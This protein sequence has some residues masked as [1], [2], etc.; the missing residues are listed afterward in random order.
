MH[1]IHVDKLEQ[2]KLFV[3][4]LKI[5]SVYGNYVSYCYNKNITY[6]SNPS[7]LMNWATW[8]YYISDAFEWEKTREGEC[9]WSTLEDAWLDITYHYDS[10]IEY[11]YDYIRGILK[12]YNII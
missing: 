1:R 6:C 9:Y 7:E 11:D 8:D 4:F 5:A 2:V 12:S 10:F 3:L